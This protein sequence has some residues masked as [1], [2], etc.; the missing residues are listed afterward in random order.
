MKKEK[1]YSVVA[2][3]L[4][5]SLLLNFV[6]AL[7]GFAIGGYFIYKTFEN[8]VTSEVTSNLDGTFGDNANKIEVG[9]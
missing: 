7:G 6:F 5:W 8:P 1:E 2:K 3:A 9:K 4:F